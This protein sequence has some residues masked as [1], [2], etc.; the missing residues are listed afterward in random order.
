MF[1]VKMKGVHRNIGVQKDLGHFCSI[2]L[3][4]FRALLAN[5][6][7]SF[8]K[9]LIGPKHFLLAKFDSGIKNMQNFM[10]IPKPL[11]KMR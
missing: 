8:K 3:T 6:A 9:V 2:Q 4:I 5:L 10:L 1:F 11:R 7:L